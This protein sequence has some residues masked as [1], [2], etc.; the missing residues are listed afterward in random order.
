MINKASYWFSAL[1]RRRLPRLTY[2]KKTNVS[3]YIWGS[4]NNGTYDVQDAGRHCTW[5]FSY[6]VSVTANVLLSS[7]RPSQSAHACFMKYSSIW[8]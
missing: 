8:F 1:V 6:S 4:M 3:A 5:C 7:Y 2:D